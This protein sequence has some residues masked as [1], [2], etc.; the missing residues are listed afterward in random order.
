[1]KLI[2][3]LILLFC[4]LLMAQSILIGS[5]TDAKTNE[6]LEYSSITILTITNP[7]KA[8]NG[9]L[10]DAK[11]QFKIT[12][13]PFG[14]YRYKVDF[15]SYKSIEGNVLIDKPFINLGNINLAVNETLLKSVVVEAEKDI[16]RGGIEKKIY[17]VGKNLSTTGGNASDVLNMV[18]SVNVD[19]EGNVTLRGSGNVSIWING[20]PT[21]IVAANKADALKAV[22]ANQIQ[23]IEIITNPSAKY[24]AEGGAGII[25]IILKKDAKA[26][27]NGNVNLTLG[28][29]LKINPSINLGYLK[30]NWRITTGYSFNN[31]PTYSYRNIDRR[32]SYKEDSILNYSQKLTTQDTTYTHNIRLSVDKS[33]SKGSF[34]VNANVNTGQFYRSELFKYTYQ[35]P[36]E[37]IYSQSDVRDTRPSSG[38]DVLGTFEYNLSGKNKISTQLSTALDQRFFTGY[39][40]IMSLNP[41]YNRNI[42]NSKTYSNVVQ[43]DYASKINNLYTLET[44]VKYNALKVKSLQDYSTI[45]T[46]TNIWQLNTL[47]SNQFVYNQTVYAGYAQFAGSNKKENIKY[48]GGLRLED[49]LTKGELITN[50][51]IFD[52]EHSNLFPSLAIKYLLESKLKNNLDTKAKM[53]AQKEFYITYSKRVNRPDASLVNP[54]PNVSDLTSLRYG[55]PDLQPEYVHSFEIGFNS[56]GKLL[57]FTSGIYYKKTLNAFSR[58]LYNDSIG[59]VRVIHSNIGI[60][61]AFG[62]EF[63]V[64]TNI[65]KK[66]D[67]MFNTDAY[68]REILSTGVTID[69]KRVV[70]FNSNFK[71]MSNYKFSKTSELQ[72]FAMYMTPIIFAQGTFQGMNML[73]LNYRKTLG[74]WTL[75]FGINDLLNTTNMQIRTSQGNFKNALLGKSETR[76]INL[77]VEYR[78]GE[79]DKKPSKSARNGSGSSGGG[80]DFF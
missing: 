39:Q 6:P 44:G 28:S 50:N 26:G 3:L 37:T 57:T 11:G 51:T 21:G 67:I 40:N 60:F 77:T 45:N 31:R 62:G 68:L 34:G 69:N 66:W 55:N 7:A 64:K 20:R 54:F 53:P 22:P 49:A 75:K 1:M 17:E 78:F 30:K 33:F 43:I 59:N 61:N 8:V 27:F 25:N 46:F 63:M 18:P 24:D 5:V 48:Q 42:N 79:V 65:T 72:L 16:I 2:N 73:N 38:Y 35:F 56:Y 32:I 74:F 10:T 12:D 47:F 36:T 29:F 41:S 76:I 80:G 14:N 58:V 13:L 70:G 15:S 71:L 9:A 19:I 23:S 4:Q 52:T